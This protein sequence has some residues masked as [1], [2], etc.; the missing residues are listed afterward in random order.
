MDNTKE[1]ISEEMLDRWYFVMITLYVVYVI[2]G[3]QELFEALYWLLNDNPC[4]PCEIY[5][6]PNLADANNFMFQRYHYR[7]FSQPKFYGIAP[8][9]LPIAGEYQL[10]HLNSPIIPESEQIPVLISPSNQM[11][12][13]EFSES[14]PS[15]AANIGMNVAQP[16]YN[17]LWAFDAMNG[18]ASSYNDLHDVVNTMAN[19]ELIYPHAITVM[20]FPDEFTVTR[21]ART[22]YT[23]RFYCRY[24]GRREVITLPDRDFYIGEIFTD[25]HYQRREKEREGN[26]LTT[27]LEQG[28]L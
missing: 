7:H 18:F 12:T 4:V 10:G 15:E 2:K 17:M 23:H 3:D 27:F 6:F 20:P 5:R 14:I 1:K 24:D 16:V 8:I 13:D 25:P 26:I 21:T 22:N 28:L 19:P 9:P 11:Y